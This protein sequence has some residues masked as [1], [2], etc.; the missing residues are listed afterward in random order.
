MRYRF[1]GDELQL[2]RYVVTVPADEMQSETEYTAVTES[3][4]DGFINMFPTAEFTEVDNSGYEWLDG[5]IWTQEQVAAGEVAKAIELGETAWNEVK[6]ASD[7]R[8]IN[9]MLML[10][11]AK[12]KAGVNNE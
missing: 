7:Q 3:E 9:A 11:I 5:T 2:V 8:K 10:E 1:Y 4:R 6:D 12:L